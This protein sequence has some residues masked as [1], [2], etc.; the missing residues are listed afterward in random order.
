VSIT[1]EEVAQDPGEVHD[2]LIE[3]FAFKDEQSEFGVSHFLLTLALGDWLVWFTLG[4]W[5]ALD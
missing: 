3:F 4:C 2:C 5:K 1:H